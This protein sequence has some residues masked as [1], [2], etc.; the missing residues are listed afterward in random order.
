VDA[1]DLVHPGGAPGPLRSLLGMTV[2]ETDACPPDRTNALRLTSPVGEL[3]EGT[4]L[5]SGV[6][7]E[8]IWLEGAEAVAV[9]EKDFYAGEPALTRNVVGA[10]RAYFLATLLTAES[11]RS[12]IGALAA[13]VGVGCPLGVEPPAGVEVSRRVAPDGAAVLYLLNHSGGEVSVPLPAGSHT[14]LLSGEVFEGS[15]PLPVRGVR[16]LAG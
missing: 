4:L 5:P 6:L 10:G 16:L 15:V 9:Y 14:D 7:C 11:L 8:R 13:E 1:D 2:E 3:A 12:L